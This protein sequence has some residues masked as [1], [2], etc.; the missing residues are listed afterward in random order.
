MI[1]K[2]YCAHIPLLALVDQPRL[3]D[4]IALLLAHRALVGTKRPSYVGCHWNRHTVRSRPDPNIGPHWSYV[5]GGVA[6][7]MDHCVAGVDD[8][9]ITRVV[10][11]VGGEGIGAARPHTG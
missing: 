9:K 6:A 2:M 3:R 5:L 1:C 8:N 11:S 4:P 7:I 10:V